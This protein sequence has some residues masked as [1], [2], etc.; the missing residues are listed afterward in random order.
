MLK[1]DGM[2]ETKETK[3]MDTAKSYKC[4]CSHGFL[5]LLSPLNFASFGGLCEELVPG[6]QIP[7]C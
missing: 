4:S 7:F 5:H 3:V 1:K 6:W 2:D